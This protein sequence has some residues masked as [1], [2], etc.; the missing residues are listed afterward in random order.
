[1]KKMLVGEL[2]D[3]QIEWTLSEL[4]LVCN[5]QEEWIINL[6]DEGML[7]P[8]GENQENWR[9]SGTSISRVHTAMRLEHDLGINIAGV[10]LVIELIDEVEKLRYRLKLYENPND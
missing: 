2:L 5:R 4:C 3:E 9:F 6:V 7:N 8:L 1:M 10:A